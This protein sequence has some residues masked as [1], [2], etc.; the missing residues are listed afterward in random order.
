MYMSRLES[1]LFGQCNQKK[2]KDF[3]YVIHD[4]LKL[5]EKLIKIIHEIN[6]LCFCKK[7]FII[8]SNLRNHIDTLMDIGKYKPGW[9]RILRDRILPRKGK[10]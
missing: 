2:M 7:N 9:D 1:L 10:K 8:P 5:G 6:Y 4:C 3:R